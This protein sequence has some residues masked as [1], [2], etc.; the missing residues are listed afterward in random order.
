[1]APTSH[2]ELLITHLADSS[3]VKCTPDGNGGTVC[4]KHESPSPVESSSWSPLVHHCLF[5]LAMLSLVVVYGGYVCRSHRRRK[6]AAAAAAAAA[7]AA[8][9]KTAAAATA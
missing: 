1:M 8:D 9:E 7:D 5:A 3:Y 6:A 2:V 4:A